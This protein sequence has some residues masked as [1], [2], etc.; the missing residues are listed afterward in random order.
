M[1]KTLL[2]TYEQTVY[3]YWQL[4]DAKRI[5]NR[6][7]TLLTLNAITHQIISYYNNVLEINFMPYWVGK[8]DNL[9]TYEEL[10]EAKEIVC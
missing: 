2:N 1:I 4:T 3:L 9:P 6:A 10:M 5:K 7:S 8:C